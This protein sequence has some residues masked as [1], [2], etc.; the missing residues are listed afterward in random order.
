MPFLLSYKVTA[1][2]YGDYDTAKTRRE[3]AW[4]SIDLILVL[5]HSPE[6]PRKTTLDFCFWRTGDIQAAW[7]N[8]RFPPFAEVQLRALDDGS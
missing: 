3:P 4:G 6:V 5:P 2:D 7:T 1:R 8:D